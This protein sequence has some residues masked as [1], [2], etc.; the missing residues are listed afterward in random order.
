[1]V[2][3]YIFNRIWKVVSKILNCIIPYQLMQYNF[4][5]IKAH[6]WFHESDFIIKN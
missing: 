6:T 5:I 4:Y 1:M 2:K 3:S